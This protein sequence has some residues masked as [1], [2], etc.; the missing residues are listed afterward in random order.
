[1]STNRRKFL[2]T[3]AALAAGAAVTGQAAAAPLQEDNS[4]LGRTAHTKFAVNLEMWWRNL[5]F[6]RRIEEAHRLGFTYFEFWPWQGKDINAIATL[7]QK[8]K[9]E[10]AQF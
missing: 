8:L 9:M 6:L 5:P 10:V 1:M 3:S 2:A 4:R 7:C